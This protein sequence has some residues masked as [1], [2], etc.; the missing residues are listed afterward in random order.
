MFYKTYSKGWVE[1]ITGTMF[2]GKSTELIRRLDTLNRAE[3]KI[4]VFSPEI[5]DRYGKNN[6]SNHNGF[7]WPAIDVKNADDLL[8][9]VK[10]DTNVVV[11]DEIQFFDMK[12]VDVVEKLANSGIRVIVAGLSADFR[13]QPFKTTMHIMARAEFVT[14]LEAVCIKCKAPATKVQRLTNGKPSSANEETINVK[15]MESYEARCRHC[16][17]INDY[18]PTKWYE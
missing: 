3:E 5:D 17:E 1:V 6:I 8:V 16:H 4:Q 18:D 11:I 7:S 15:G 9:K 10:K 2:A 13:G 12:I 14:K